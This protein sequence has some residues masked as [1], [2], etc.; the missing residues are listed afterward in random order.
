MGGAIGVSALGAV[1]TNS[2]TSLLVDH[3]GAAATGAAAP[4]CPRRSRCPTL[5]G[6]ERRARE[7]AAAPQ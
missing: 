4:R 3:F 1:L 7:A 5:T 2:V 6:D